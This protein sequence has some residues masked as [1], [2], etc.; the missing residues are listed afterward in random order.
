MLAG[1]D[2]KAIKR[3]EAIYELVYSEEAY[4]RDVDGLI[5]VYLTPIQQK[6]LIDPALMTKM[7]TR[8]TDVQQAG[9][10]LLK[11][12]K[13]RQDATV[14]VKQLSD[15]LEKHVETVATPFYNYCEV[16]LEIRAKTTDATPELASFM[17]ATMNSAA[18]RGLSMDAYLLAPVQRMVR[19]PMLIS[20]VEKATLDDPS[21]KYNLSNA[22]KRWKESVHTCNSRFAE[23]ENW[24][25]LK[26]LQK[27]LNYERVEGAEEIWKP[28]HKFGYRGIV[29][30]GPLEL[31]KLNEAK[32]KI[33]KRK[34][35]EVMLFSDIFLFCKPVKVKKTGR[36][37]MIVIKEAHRSLLDVDRFRSSGAQVDTKLENMIE[38][39]FLS[40]D[41][42][43]FA[44]GEADAG[45]ETLYI[46]AKDRMTMDRW[47]E[48][49][50]PPREDED[51][52]QAWEC[53]QFVVLKD[54]TPPRDEQGDS[55][56][57]RKGEIV[58]VEKRGETHMKGR[59]KD[60]E[61]FASYNTSGYFPAGHVKEIESHRKTAREVRGLAKQNSQAY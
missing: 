24:F 59:L 7:M 45:M 56:P 17:V 37:E 12:L 42:K 43:A 5:S 33:A 25:N 52:Y 55:M 57:L 41:K 32:K 1:M 51:I 35:V 50:N 19:Y 27:Q 20:E 34:Q 26:D 3:Q 40:K 6:G 28:S 58:E 10:A 47:L 29:K 13:A 21:E 16:V 15:V 8:I 11:D 36:V 30:K 4:L 48:A 38:I 60:P 44:S 2:S 18:S 39:R 9:K 46:K 23:I 54:W 31:I 22:H 61:P 49:F 14:V 53:P